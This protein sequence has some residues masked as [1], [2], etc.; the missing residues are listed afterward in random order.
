[1]NFSHTGSH[2]GEIRLAP[3]NLADCIDEA[4]HLLQLDLTAA[5][6]QFNNVCDR[7]VVVLAD[8]Q[9]L[10]Q[11]FIN[12]LGNA[13]DACGDDAKVLVSADAADSQVRIDV[14]DNGCGIPLELQGQVFEPFFTTKDPGAGTGLGLA[15]VYSIMDD[16]GGKVHITSP[17]TEGDNPGT[18]VT[19]HLQR[20]EY[21]PAP[22]G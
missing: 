9:R 22:R 17:L 12:L 20:T 3:T 13:R 18:R 7:E 16:M 19:L 14:E 2:S 21:E 11:V 4:I 8:S 10:L 5:P 15:L 1:M 6:V